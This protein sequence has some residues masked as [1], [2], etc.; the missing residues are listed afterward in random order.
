VIATRPASFSM[1]TSRDAYRA[2]RLPANQQ[3]PESPPAITRLP[4]HPRPP[5][6]QVPTL[7]GCSR[8]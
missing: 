2:P 5:S 1:S 6:P 4:V 7:I 8:C 3:P